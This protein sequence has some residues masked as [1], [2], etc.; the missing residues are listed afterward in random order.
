MNNSKTEVRSLFLSWI[1]ISALIYLL[2]V[3]VGVIGVGFDWISGGPKGAEKLFSFATN[4]I[5]GVILGTLAT[6]LVQSSSTVTSVIVALVAGGMPVEIAVP[7][8]MG[9]NMGTTITNTIVSLGNIRETKAFHRSFSAA[10]VHDFFNLYAILIFLPIEVVFHPLQRTAGVMASWLLDGGSA[11]I[12]NINVLSL[13]IKPV[14]VNLEQ[15]FRGIPGTVDASLFTAFGIGLVF[16]SVIYMSKLLKSVM[17]GRAKAMLDKALGKGV[18]VGIFAGALITM[19]VQSSSTTTSLL[20][21]LAGAGVL[22]LRQVF[23]FTLG[24]NIGTTITA[25]LAAT[26]ILGGNKIFALQIAL[27][28][29]LFNFSGVILFALVPWLYE[30][31]IRSAE[32]LGGLTE[33]NR[34]YAFGYIFGVFFIIPGSVFGGQSILNDLDPEVV[35]AEQNTEQMKVI[36]QELDE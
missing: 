9:A 32:W 35:Q 26:A 19:I 20:V 34:G 22:S 10:T 29:F 14:V 6:A 18:L 25:L 17:T 21:P 2:M 4:P 30:L 31:P 3:G 13:I 28:H 5:V 1:G 16:F 11:S 36:E 24:A 12:S 23:P 27:V 7:M 15:V 33:R 8:V